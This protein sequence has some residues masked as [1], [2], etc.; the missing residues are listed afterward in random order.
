MNQT[1]WDRLAS[2]YTDEVHDNLGADRLGVITHWLDQM[3]SSRKSA[4][5]FGCGIGHYL[6]DLSGRFRTV[7]ALDHSDALLERARASHGELE[8]IT[9]RQADL[10]KPLKPWKA[11]D[12]G[13]CMNVLIAPDHQL[14]TAMVRTIHHAL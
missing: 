12:I 2:N 4:V 6:R 13:V 10:S 8:N 5:D 11:A 9:Y 3:A 7:A 14:R 1:Y